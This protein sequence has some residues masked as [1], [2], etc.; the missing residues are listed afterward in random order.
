MKNKIFFVLSLLFGLMFINAGLN[1]FFYYMP[2]PENLP[3][4]MQKAMNAFTEIGWI[5]PLVGAAE[6]LGG[7][8]I[9]IPRFR[10]LGALIILPVLAGIL[11]TNIVQ[12][13]SGLPL[14][15]VLSA[16][17]ISIMYQNKEKYSALF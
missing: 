10:A 16:I 15:L 7:V 5:M 17:L 11:L 12:D 3:E 9:I 2:M 4:K 6:V 8:L 1:K 14:V 13:T